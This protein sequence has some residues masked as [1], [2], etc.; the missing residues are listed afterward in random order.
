MVSRRIVAVGQLR[1]SVSSS[2]AHLRASFGHATPLV[3]RLHSI[4][5][6]SRPQRRSH[7]SARRSATQRLRSLRGH[8]TPRRPHGS[9]RRSIA[10]LLPVGRASPSIRSV[11]RLHTSLSRTTPPVARS[12]L[13][14]LQSHD[15]VHRSATQ[16]L[17][18]GRTTPSLA[19]SRGS[20]RR[21]VAQLRM[22]CMTP[23]VARSRNSER[24]GRRTPF[25]TRSQNSA[26]VA[27]LRPPTRRRVSADP[28]A[29]RRDERISP[30][31]GATESS[32]CVAGLHPIREARACIC[33]EQLLQSVVVASRSRRTIFRS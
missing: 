21:S 11:T 27:R 28:G 13:R 14:P 15:S 29:A 24:L 33:G 20:P 8:T 31:P 2:V 16:R 30:R 19:R 9:I 4:V 6:R 25:I 26:S 18:V 32:H 23:P 10:Q 22:G 5:G 17:R 3:G 1:D 12:R 7:D